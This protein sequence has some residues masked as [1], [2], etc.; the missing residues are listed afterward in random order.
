MN[1]ILRLLYAIIITVLLVS[2]GGND[3][4]S[5][6]QDIDNTLVKVKDSKIKETLKKKPL[7]YGKVESFE[8]VNDP[9][10][11]SS[12]SINRF[13]IPADLNCIGAPELC[14]EVS[15]FIAGNKLVFNSSE[16][17]ALIEGDSPEYRMSQKGTIEINN[18]TYSGA[19]YYSGEGNIGGG[20]WFKGRLTLELPEL[21]ALKG[22]LLM[23][24]VKGKE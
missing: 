10:S 17:Y 12:F 13:I 18:K 1:I 19:L 23:L 14:K 8:W 7:M 9:L 2:C 20:S 4:A 6:A 22:E 3:K 16:E 15:S 11:E 5:D 21:K 24:E